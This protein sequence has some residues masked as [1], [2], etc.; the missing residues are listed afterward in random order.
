MAPQGGTPAKYLSLSDSFGKHNLKLSLWSTPGP[1]A[2]RFRKLSLYSL[3]YEGGDG[4]KCGAKF[5]DTSCITI[6]KPS[7]GK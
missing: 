1:H 6:A 3:I 4:A 5:A 2:L 7:G